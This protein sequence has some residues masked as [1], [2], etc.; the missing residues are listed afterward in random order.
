VTESR[1]PIT[2]ATTPGPFQKETDSITGKVV[3]RCGIQKRSRTFAGTGAAPI[4]PMVTTVLVGFEK[5]ANSDY[6]HDPSSPG[7][8][9]HA[10]LRVLMSLGSVYLKFRQTFDHGLGTAYYRDV[11]RPRILKTH[12][13]E[14]TT[15][16]RCEI[17]ALT[18][19]QDWLNLIWTLKSFYAA[20]GRKY[21]L[22]IHDDGSLDD[23]ARS[24]LQQ[25]FPAARLIL[26]AE[27]DAK[28]AEVLR[29][30]P[31]CLKFRNTNL[32]APKV[33]DFI[34]YL[35]SERMGLFDS[36]LLF[37]QEPTAYLQRIEDS[38]YRKNT[39]NADCGTSAYTIEPDVVRRHLGFELHPMVNSGLGLIHRDSMRW[40]WVEEFLA[41]PGI[42]DGHF[43][44]IEQ[45]IYALCSSRFG[46]ELLPDEYRV[47]L[48][49][50]IDSRPF[51][52]YVGAV[53]HLM[54]KEGMS[55][56]VGQGL[57][58]VAG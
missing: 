21:A 35:Q 43:W 24:A 40:D 27:A 16:S 50:G 57:L 12:P 7:Q 38:S 45:T 39:F 6:A 53:R 48:A 56:L 8:L 31:R 42:L 58:A 54:Y 14:G 18:Y 1:P 30:Y 2:L 26:R 19:S 34:A 15:D 22:C 9:H 32:L 28:L 55:T 29:D 46:V 41:L 36:D 3:I 13:V 33:F 5:S 10:P 52:H 23:A 49:H 17:H 25:H 20:S 44:R 4:P 11:V 37:F 51:R 47:Y